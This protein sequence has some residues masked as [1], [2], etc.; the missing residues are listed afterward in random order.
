MLLI[1]FPKPGSPGEPHFVAIT[2]FPRIEYYTLERGLTEGGGERTVLCAWTPRGHENYGTGPEPTPEA[3]LKALCRLLKMPETIEPPLPVQLCGATKG[4]GTAII[5]NMPL[6]MSAEKEAEA[7][8]LK[9]LGDEARALKHFEQA[10]AFYRSVYELRIEEQGYESTIATL[11]LAPVIDMFLE[12][13]AFAEA[14]STCAQW[15]TVCR[16]YRIPGHEE[17]M[18]ATRILIDALQAQD[19]QAEVA[20][21]LQHRIQYFGLMR[22]KR[23]AQYQTAVNDAESLPK[24]NRFGPKKR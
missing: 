14:E 24:S 9:K 8:R 20:A 18:L 13:G 22:G 1:H 3:F 11:S 15:W 5:G 6:P 21:L 19:K 12:L 23:S 4:T 2:T 10:E 16:R 17:G 7:E